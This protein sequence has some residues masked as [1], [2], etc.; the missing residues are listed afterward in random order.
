MLGESRTLFWIIGSLVELDEAGGTI[1]YSDVF[2]QI[3][4]AAKHFAEVGLDKKYVRKYICCTIKVQTFHCK[5][6]GFTVPTILL[7]N[8]MSVPD[9][10]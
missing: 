9:F 3:E 7:V 5:L 8:S 10:N 1:G 4:Q 2:T 6:N